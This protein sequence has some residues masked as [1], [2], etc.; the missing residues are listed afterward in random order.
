[1]RYEPIVQIGRGGMAE[2]LLAL[3]HAGGD[4]RRLAV[5]KRTW[6]E[7]ATDPEFVTMFLDEARLA[8]R[9]AHANVVQTY[10]VLTGEG[11]LAIAMEYLDGQ[12][13]TRV[14]NRLLRG[15]S[16]L[17]LPLRLRIVCSVLAGLEYAHTLTDLEG[18]PLELVHR[19]VSPANIFITYD[20]QVKL[21]DFGVAKTLAASHHTRPGTLK[22]KIAYMAP[23]QMQRPFVDRRA[24]LFS[25]GVVLWE[26]LAAR[27]MW[28]GMTEVDIVAHLAAGRA[29]PALPAPAE[30]G[31]PAGLDAIC[32]RA[33]EPDPDRRYQ[34]AAE[35]ESEIER[36]LI[37]SADS[38]A[39]NLGKVVSLAFAAERAERQA[40]VERHVR[41]SGSRAAEPAAPRASDDAP[42]GAPSIDLTLSGLDHPTVLRPAPERRFSPG[43]FWLR[44]LATVSALVGVV[45]VLLLASNRPPFVSIP[46]VAVAAPAPPP[47]SP[48]ATPASGQPVAPLPNPAVAKPQPAR[49][50]L[51]ADGAPDEPARPR[52]RHRRPRHDEDGTLPPS[53]ELDP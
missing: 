20:G 48:A 26:M 6:P 5:L 38:H 35:M 31:L 24:D 14:L 49:P 13:L 42:E 25:V 11:E 15:R 27:R 12:P 39:R 9:L 23:E 43:W 10:E 18:T 8:L 32:A 47:P 29:M 4:V 40:I 1:M 34:T 2:V 53:V 3:V 16:D 51:T 21:V 41:R 17:P 19:D 33:L 44:R 22:G 36:V 46:A 45:A 37:G 52:P 7:L 50:L 30:A 28:Q